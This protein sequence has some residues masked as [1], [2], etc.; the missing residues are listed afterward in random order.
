MKPRKGRRPYTRDDMMQAAQ[1]LREAGASYGDIAYFL[2]VSR[3]TAC[4]WCN[5]D[6]AARNSQITQAWLARGGEPQPKVVYARK[7]G[8]CRHCRSLRSLGRRYDGLCKA[9]YTGQQILDRKRWIEKR[10][11]D[12]MSYPEMA[13]ELGV[14][15]DALE[16]TIE[17]MRA[18][19]Y[20]LPDRDESAFRAEYG[21]AANRAGL[22][23]DC[24]KMKQRGATYRE[25]SERTGVP[26]GTLASWWRAEKNKAAA[27]SSGD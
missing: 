21:R 7:R 17:A 19:G 10:W 20:V 9:C 8:V 24:V 16:K 6:V 26:R 13:G 12:G 18:E 14:S 5:D 4:R 22:R 15:I 3:M 23:A 25:I 2:G 27:G 11:G 1:R